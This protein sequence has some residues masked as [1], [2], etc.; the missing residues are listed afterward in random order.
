MTRNRLGIVICLCL[1]WF[2]L[3][4]S[5]AHGQELSNDTIRLQLGESPDG[6]PMIEEAVWLETGQ[7][8]FRRVEGSGILSDWFADSL[9][10][11]NKL[12]GSGSPWE[13]TESPSFYTAEA[14][15]RFAS[16]LEVTWVA[17][18]ARTGSL[19]RLH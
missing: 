9:I 6:I 11:N 8:A 18:L 16:G 13:I 15:R 17:E 7:A 10:Q 4:V 1:T 2:A 19:I 3:D 5:A 14:T 12:N